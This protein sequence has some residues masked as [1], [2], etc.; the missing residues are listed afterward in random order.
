[1]TEQIIGFAILTQLLIGTVIYSMGYRD[2]KSVGY[3]R[4]RSVKMATVSRIRVR[5]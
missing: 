5:R 4:G 3:E 1:M 2:G